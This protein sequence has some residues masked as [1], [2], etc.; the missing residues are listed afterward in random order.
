[1]QGGNAMT[2]EKTALTNRSTPSLAQP[3][4]SQVRTVT[5]L[6]DIYENK[7]EILVVADFPGVPEK[8]LTVEL[9]RSELSIEGQQATPEKEGQPR[10]LRF[11]RAFRVPNT[12]DPKGV[13]ATLS[14][15]VL[16]VHLTKSEAAKP[17]RIEVRSG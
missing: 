2:T 5:P 15:G 9:D 14:R 3:D 7:D 6:V 16:H 1:M 17:R 8:A 11:Y 12:V 4:E 10:P 13:S